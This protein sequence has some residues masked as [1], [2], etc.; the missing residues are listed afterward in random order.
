[1]KTIKNKRLTFKAKI[2]E[3]LADNEVFRV[4][5]RDGNF[6]MTKSQFHSVFGNIVKS[7]SYSQSQYRYTYNY[8]KAPP[9]AYQF[10]IS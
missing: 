6:E 10:L 7:K 5:C 3:P 2:I 9:E 8:P 4:E 1:M